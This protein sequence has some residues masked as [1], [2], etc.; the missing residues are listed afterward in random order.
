MKFTIQVN[1]GP[2]QHQA[3]DSAYHFT[4]A[5]LRKGH[6][7]VRVFFFHDGVLNGSRL[8]SPPQDDRHIVVRWSQLAADFEVDL[9]A[10]VAAAQRRGILDESAAQGLT[11]ANLA[12]GFRLGG[13]G[14]LVE[15]VL[16][17]DRL[18]TFGD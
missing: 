9:V 18:I 15:A 16:A 3:S 17:G 2:Y 8:I 1:A 11:G 7:I 5:A 10:C 4:L 14:Q 12:P 6:E 13:L